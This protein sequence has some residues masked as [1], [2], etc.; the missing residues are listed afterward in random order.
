MSKKL[1]KYSRNIKI[2]YMS[3]IIGAFG[4]IYNSIDTLYYKHFGLSFAQ[5]GVFLSVFAIFTFIF[6]IPS[7]VY[8]DIYGRKKSLIVSG[9]LGLIGL[10]FITFGSTY[11][12]FLVSAAFA[13]TSSAFSSGAKDAILFESLKKLKKENHLVKIKGHLGSI[14][15]SFDVIGGWYIPLIFAFNVRIP[16]QIALV[17]G[18]ISLIVSF[19]LYEESRIENSGGNV[20][21]N[22]KSTFNSSITYIR[23][24]NVLKWVILL[25]LN[26]LV[27][28]RVFGEMLSM[29]H[30][31]D[32]LGIEGLRVPLALHAIIQAF[33]VFYASKIEKYLG[34]TKML[35][36]MS[37][38]TPITLIAFFVFDN[39]ILMTIILG[40]V[41]SINSLGMLMSSKWEQFAIDDDSKRATINSGVQ[42]INSLIFIPLLPLIGLFIDNLSKLRMS[43][44]LFGLFI[45]LTSSLLLKFR[46]TH[47]RN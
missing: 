1:K 27:I 13:G 16:Y 33:I 35:W 18:V 20:V 30:M 46:P 22:F 5:I 8:A 24:S 12:I 45:L 15:I 39:V 31:Q 34:D 36:M 9:L 11:E 14:G 47:L 43:G 4:Y 10:C 26:Y 32:T 44:I 19:F 29:P 28:W 23:S 37:F 3:A 21:T 41:W 40:L 2:Y 7:G 17:A 42:L 25:N 38:L 6:E